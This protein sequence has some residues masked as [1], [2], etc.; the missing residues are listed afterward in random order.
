MGG[1]T[2]TTNSN[3]DFWFMGFT[4]QL[5]AGAWVGCDDRFITLESSAYYGG[6]VARPIWEAFFKK[7]YADKTLG[8]ERDA[9]FAR[10]AELENEINSADIMDLI[11]NVEPGAEGTDQGVGT[12]DDY[13]LNN[14]YIGPESKP[15]PAEENPKSPAKKDTMRKN[16][17]NGEAR[18]I[19]SA[20][21]EPKKK[22]GFLKNLFG[23]KDKD[24]KK[25]R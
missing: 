3:A 25:D 23:K 1:K 13:N 10:P 17:P 20:V 19:G 4:P 9:K 14:Y 15:L 2:G 6:S 11:E 16:P 22:K 12:E 24:E 18:P 5:Q 21:D 7:V 8:V